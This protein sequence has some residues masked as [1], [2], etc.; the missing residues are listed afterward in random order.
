[1]RTNRTNLL[2]S[3]H[4]YSNILRYL[5]IFKL[6]ILII[7][8]IILIF[9]LIFGVLIFKQNQK[10]EMLGQ[11]KQDNLQILSTKKDD[12]VKLIKIANKIK[13][14]EAFSKD[15]ANFYPYYQIL[16]QTFSLSTE[17][18]KIEDL[19]IQKDRKF[20]FSLSFTD[21][22]SLLETFKFIESEEFLKNF[23]TI[24]LKNLETQDKQGIKLYR[25][26]FEGTFK[27]IWNQKLV[28]ILNIY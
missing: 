4:G 15:D 23:S 1:M 24:F 13:N 25:I 11:Q 28:H 7:S 21:L 22:K 18:A 26:T 9:V 8:S 20:N 17:E 2:I 27:E 3:K 16:N 6:L 14:L 12:E 5:K 10:L 19:N